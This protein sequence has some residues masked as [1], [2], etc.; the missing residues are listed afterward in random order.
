MIC[1]T[2][3]LTRPVAVREGW[4]LSDTMTVIRLVVPPNAGLVG[5]ER[6]PVAGFT[7]TPAGAPAP[8]AKERMAKGFA[9]PAETSSE[10]VWPAGMLT[11]EGSEI[12]G[13]KF[14]PITVVC[15]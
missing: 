8:S 3:T 5:Q 9:S 12:V 6:W 7:V 10:R 1:C 14:V 13:A 15:A 4:L 11:L 2:A